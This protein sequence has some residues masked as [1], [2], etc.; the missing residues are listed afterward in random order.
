MLGDHVVP[1]FWILHELS[2]PRLLLRLA[3]ASPHELTNCEA[4][5]QN[6]EDD[7]KKLGH[8]AFSFCKVG[9]PRC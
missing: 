2:E 8:V 4:N 3:C 1:M 5:D 6:D 7:N 9:N